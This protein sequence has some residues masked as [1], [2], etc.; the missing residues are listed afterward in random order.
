MGNTNSYLIKLFPFH[1]WSIILARALK[2]KINSLK[3]LKLDRYYYYHLIYFLA[4]VT[5]KVGHVKAPMTASIIVKSPYKPLL[6][7]I[8]P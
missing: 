3:L 4:K 5:M 1:N 2:N 7:L 6:A 8:T